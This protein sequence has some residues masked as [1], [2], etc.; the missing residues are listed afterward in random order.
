MRRSRPWQLCGAFALSLV[1]A[2][3][4]EV[5][6]FPHGFD[7]DDGDALD[8]EGDDAPAPPT[9]GN[10]TPAGSGGHV[11]PPSVKPS[12]TG[13][14][15]DGG[16]TAAGLGGAGGASAGGKSASKGGTMGRG[17]AGNSAGAA[18]KATTGGGGTGPVVPA[19][20]ACQ[21]AKLTIESGESSSNE[22]PSLGP[23][24]AFDGVVTTRWSSAHSE[25]QWLAVDLGEVVRI[26]RVLIRWETAYAADYQVAIAEEADGPWEPLF[27]DRE[28]DGQTDDVDDFE[29][30][31]G[32]F[33]R[34][35]GT[36]R[37]T[38]FGFSILELELYGDPDEA[39]IAK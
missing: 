30:T 6:D 33:V 1:A 35:T 29:P 10:A 24:Y 12:G 13:D 21:S 9:G 3:A 2:C 37:G 7:A 19:H 34:M 27:R 4:H 31:S 25:P 20:V 39:C 26:S 5:Q 32:R 28:G 14:A 17:G 18:G 8:N 22:D 11:N 15:G 38:N 36:K 16:A 23:M